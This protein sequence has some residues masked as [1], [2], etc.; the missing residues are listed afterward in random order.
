MTT[1][2]PAKF[3]FPHL[4][5]MSKPIMVK[6][7]PATIPTT[8]AKAYTRVGKLKYFWI[9]LSPLSM[10][11]AKAAA[12][13]TLNGLVTLFP[14]HIAIIICRYEECVLSKAEMKMHKWAIEIAYIKL[15]SKLQID[16]MKLSSLVNGISTVAAQ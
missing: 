8:K 2:Y 10:A 3:N 5:R 12:P 4:E 1:K 6:H 16:T 13:A 9:L 7:A 15:G 14:A 11:G